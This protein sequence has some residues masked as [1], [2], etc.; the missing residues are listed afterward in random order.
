MKEKLEQ[1]EKELTTKVQQQLSYVNGL[2][3]NL[4]KAESD[5]IF[6]QGALQQL[7]ELIQE[8]TEFK[9]NGEPENE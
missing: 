7:K 6:L 8:E 2:K 1:K 4:T 5:L 3:Q 9:K